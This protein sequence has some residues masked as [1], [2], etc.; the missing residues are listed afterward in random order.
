MKAQG[1]FETLFDEAAEAI[2]LVDPAGRI[3]LMNRTC[4]ALFGYPPSELLGASIEILVPE[5][6]RGGHAAHRE[7]FQAQPKRRPMGTGLELMGRRKNGS[8]FPVDI[9]LNAHGDEGETLCVVRDMTQRV[10]HESFERALL[11]A[12]S[13]GIVMASPDGIVRSFNRGAELLWGYAASE[14]VGQKSMHQLCAASAGL[15]LEPGER[16]ESILRKDGGQTPVRVTITEL[17]RGGL[18]QGSCCIVVDMT[19]SEEARQALRKA[20]DA[21]SRF[22]ARASHELRT[23]LNA[24]LGFSQLLAED[25]A[26]RLS[27]ASS[28]YLERIRA[29]G[30]RLLRLTNDLLELSRWEMGSQSLNLEVFDAEP[31]LEELLTDF[32]PEA[33]RQD[34]EFEWEAEKGLALEADRLRIGQVMTNLVANALKFTP[35][36]GRVKVEARAADGGVCLAV[37]DDGPGIAPEAQSHIFEEFFQIQ[38]AGRAASPGTGLGLPIAKKLVEAHGGR[39]TLESELGR[40]SCFRVYLRRAANS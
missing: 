23:P 30:E 3:V 32:R 38:G 35:K 1:L 5:R 19:A 17:R 26:G 31:F 2:F 36:G 7:K 11:S 8:E 33:A 14:V 34:M 9:T 12:T 13:C 24:I 21:R 40:G 10:A 6:L 16:D 22:F 18:A 20:Y 27:P 15:N 29:G 39:L 37:S 28:R 4:E 25:S